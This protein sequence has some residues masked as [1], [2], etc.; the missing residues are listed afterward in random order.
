MFPLK[1]VRY[2]KIFVFQF[3]EKDAQILICCGCLGDQS[4]GVNEIIECDGCGVTVHE[5]CYGVFDSLS[6]ASTDS[7][8]PTTPWFCEACKAGFTFF[9]Y[10]SNIK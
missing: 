1:K 7:V 2:L 6:L 4:D 5:A 8:S 10:Y 9:L 3:D